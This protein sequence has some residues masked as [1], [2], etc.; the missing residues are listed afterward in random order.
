VAIDKLRSD[1]GEIPRDWRIASV[2]LNSLESL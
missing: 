1:I 2:Y